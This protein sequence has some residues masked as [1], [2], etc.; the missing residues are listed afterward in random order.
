MSKKY[1]QKLR[2]IIDNSKEDIGVF[3]SFILAIFPLSFV[4][5]SYLFA[6]KNIEQN[7]GTENIQNIFLYVFL[8]LAV[9]LMF[10]L[11]YIINCTIKIK[12]RRYYLLFIL[13]IKKKDFWKRR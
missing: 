1:I 7:K 3:I 8:F 12:A 11:I 4:T 10:V 13:G 6:L 9:G 5:N 2:W